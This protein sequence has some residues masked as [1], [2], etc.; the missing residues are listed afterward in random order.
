MMLPQTQ[1]L[2]LP[3]AG[4]YGVLTNTDGND[5]YAAQW[6]ASELLYEISS[7]GTGTCVPKAMTSFAL[8]TMVTFQ[9][10]LP[11]LLLF[12]LLRWQCAML[13][14][15]LLFR[16]SLYQENGMLASARCPHHGTGGSLLRASIV[17]RT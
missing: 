3:E 17:V 5:E 14:N 4:A 8:H 7:G 2:L 11:M 15:D 9:I 10:M 16:V 1:I 6:I 12:G 13:A